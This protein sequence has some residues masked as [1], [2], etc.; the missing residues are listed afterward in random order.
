MKYIGFHD[1][2]DLPFKKGQTVVI[3]AGVVVRSTNPSARERVTKR[4]QTIKVNHLMNGREVD[5]RDFKRYWPDA[6]PYKSYER[7]MESNSGKK[8]STGIWHVLEN[9]SVVWPGSG[10][11][12]CEVDINDI[13]EIN[14]IT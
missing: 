5:D 4:K 14:G 11:Y 12:W 3:P 10:G 9:P 6:T 1:T 13:L 2:K 8:Y 7:F